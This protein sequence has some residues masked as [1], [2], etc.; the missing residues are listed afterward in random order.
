MIL[1]HDRGD[2]NVALRRCIKYAANAT[3]EYEFYWFHSGGVDQEELSRHGIEGI[4]MSNR[5]PLGSR[6][7]ASLSW[8]MNNTE[9]DYMMQLGSD[10]V[11]TKAAYHTALA[12][13]KSGCPMAAYNSIGIVS[14]SCQTWVRYDCPGTMGAG[15]FISRKVLEIAHTEAEPLWKPHKEKGLDG[16]SEGAVIWR[17]RTIPQVM[18]CY[19]IPVYDFKGPSNLHGYEKFVKGGEMVWNETALSK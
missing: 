16:C 8:L 9:F 12:W 4:F 15:R 13:M 17:A 10:D 3:P 1:T 5:Q 6:L 11:M 19:G 18:T 14:P 2:N 7:N